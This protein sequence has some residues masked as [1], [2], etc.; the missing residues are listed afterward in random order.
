MGNSIT[1]YFIPNYDFWPKLCIFEGPF[2]HNLAKNRHKVER[3]LVL[4]RKLPIVTTP[5]IFGRVLKNKFLCEFS[6]LI[7]GN[8]IKFCKKKTKKIK[9]PTLEAN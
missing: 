9:F 1:D 7:R 8:I 4:C 3:I 6:I 5:I 2:H